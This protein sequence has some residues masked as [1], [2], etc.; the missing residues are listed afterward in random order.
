[1]ISDIIAGGVM[2]FVV[3]AIV[4]GVGVNLFII[5]ASMFATSQPQAQTGRLVRV[6]ERDYD[7]DED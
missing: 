5:V 1:M 4:I 7:Y 3:G 2:L 6:H